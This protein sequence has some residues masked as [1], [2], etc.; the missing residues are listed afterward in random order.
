MHNGNF[1]V[2]LKASFQKYF[3]STL[4]MLMAIVWEAQ[5]SIPTDD[6]FFSTFFLAFLDGF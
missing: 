3:I 1:I 2:E 4:P 6:K 5:G